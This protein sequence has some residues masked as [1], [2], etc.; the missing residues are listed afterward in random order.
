MKSTRTALSYSLVCLLLRS[1]TRT[2]HSFARFALLSLLARSATLTCLLIHSVA[3]ELMGNTSELNESTWCSFNLL[4]KGNASNWCSFNL[5]CEGAR[6]WK[7]MQ[8]PTSRQKRGWKWLRHEY[9]MS[10]NFYVLFN[11]LAPL[12]EDPSVLPSVAPS[13]RHSVHP[14]L[15]LWN[16]GAPTGHYWPVNCF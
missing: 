16:F 5:L 13:V 3:P 2:A 12:Q 15:R 14:S 8:R 11:K 9:T 4:C 1:F 10:P 7:W 6:K